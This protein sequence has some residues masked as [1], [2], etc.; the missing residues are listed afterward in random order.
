MLRSC[1]GWNGRELLVSGGMLAFTGRVL[2]VFREKHSGIWVG[3]VLRLP[4]PSPWRRTC[5]PVARA[6]LKTV[7][8]LVLL[9][10][11]FFG[12][13]TLSPRSTLFLGWVGSWSRWA[14]PR[15]MYGTEGSRIT[16]FLLPGD[17]VLLSF[18]PTPV[19][20]RLGGRS[21]YGGMSL[22]TTHH[23]KHKGTGSGV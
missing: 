5:A 13:N 21:P 17:Q 4:T 9:H 1:L 10:P 16:A 18:L 19:L 20:E 23:L 8:M 7:A 3:L 6:W 14:G 2:G 15:D 22:R 12:P 11:L